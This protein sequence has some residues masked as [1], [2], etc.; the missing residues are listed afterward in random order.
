MSF[1]RERVTTKMMD[2]KRI[3]Q[4]MLE[5]YLVAGKSYPQPLPPA[6]QAWYCYTSDGG[7][8]ILCAIASRYRKGTDSS[9]FL[10]PA[11]VKSVLRGYTEQDGY[12]V[13]DLPYDSQVG[14]VT[15]GED[16]EY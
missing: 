4:Q 3:V 14:L 9:G 13:V 6:L 1:L 8:S 15:P 16:D 2:A 7:H 11:P 12:I 5:G 10:V